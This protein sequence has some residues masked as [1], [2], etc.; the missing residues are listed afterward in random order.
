[1]L[2]FVACSAPIL[3]GHGNRG[4]IRSSAC[5]IQRLRLHFEYDDP[6]PLVASVFAVEPLQMQSG[7]ESGQ[8]V[9]CVYELAGLHLMVRTAPGLHIRPGAVSGKRPLPPCG[10]VLLGWLWSRRDMLL[11]LWA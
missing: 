4:S 7:F 6:P 2:D 1:M 11:V 8:P 9:P 3:P 5:L 10:P